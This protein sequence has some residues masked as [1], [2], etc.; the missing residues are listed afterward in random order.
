[1]WILSIVLGYL[2]DLWLLF[3]VAGGVLYVAGIASP[4]ALSKTASNALAIG[5]A[6]VAVYLWT[7]ASAT[8]AYEA[9]LQAAVTAERA[10]ILAITETA[11]TDARKAA[12]D[13]EAAKGELERRLADAL[14]AIPEPPAGTVHGGGLSPK[15]T[16]LLLKALGK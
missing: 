13:A 12:A 11:I 8:Q 10:R 9:R 5:C 14:D 7:Y 3:A 4:G 2:P 15:S 1:M 16:D 6:V